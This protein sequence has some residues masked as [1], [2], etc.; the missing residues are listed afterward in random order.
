ML[1]SR[2]TLLLVS[3]VLH[4][5]Q[6]ISH[7]HSSTSPPPPV[8]KLDPATTATLPQVPANIRPT[9]SPDTEE[10]SDK[11][12]ET[13][14][15]EKKVLGLFDEIPKNGTFKVKDEVENFFKDQ[16]NAK[17]AD[18][19]DLKKQIAVLDRH[20]KKHSEFA[21]FNTT[22]HMLLDLDEK[23]LK[24]YE[25]GL[26]VLKN[27]IVEADHDNWSSTSVDMINNIV[28]KAE[29]FIDISYER[30]YGTLDDHLESDEHKNEH[31]HG[32][33]H[34]HSEDHAAD[35]ADLITA[36]DEM[37]DVSSED[38]QLLIE[39]IDM[40]INDLENVIKQ[41]DDLEHHIEDH[42]KLDNVESDELQLVM[43]ENVLQNLDI[44][45]LKAYE[46][47]LQDLKSQIKESNGKLKLEMVDQISATME[48]AEV[49][50]DASQEK[51]NLVGDLDEEFEVF[52]ETEAQP[53]EF[54]PVTEPYE[55]IHQQND[56]VIS[57]AIKKTTTKETINSYDEESIV[58]ARET[59]SRDS[60]QVLPEENLKLN[61]KAEK[62]LI[63][64]GFQLPLLPFHFSA[65][66]T[67][68]SIVV[69]VGMVGAAAYRM[70]HKAQVEKDLSCESGCASDKVG[71]VTKEMRSPQ[72]Q[73]VNED[74]DWNSKRWAKTWA[75]EP[76]RRKR[77]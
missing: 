43:A 34:G 65:T 20:L 55:N 36:E 28:S 1:F 39:Y 74:D 62:V 3:L 4:Q 5:S 35:Y 7:P 51:L 21:D 13:S 30:V 29:K 53:E 72:L 17:I 63:G 67:I 58:K 48:K 64:E 73:V 6:A 24:P 11:K 18:F 54:K 33:G 66:L 32:H 68:L 76:S 59:N 44:E 22:D 70:V 26:K 8:R 9:L 52:E 57:N 10:D 71:L 45:K 69:L 25:D 40:D 61:E 27:K 77:K 46:K 56:P 2:S 42:F 23:V 41:K 14:S 38:E 75:A 19:E 50:L 31:A 47:S 49:F 60:K 37:V 12:V 15:G 16:I